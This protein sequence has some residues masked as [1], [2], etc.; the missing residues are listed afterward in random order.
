MAYQ[1]GL[2]PEDFLDM[3]PRD[4]ILMQRA[5]TRNEERKD[6]GEWTRTRWLAC[7]LMQPHLRKGR[8]LKPKDLAVF[9]W[10]TETKKKGYNRKQIMK[11]AEY[12]RKL[13]EKINKENGK[14]TD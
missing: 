3:L 12:A 1:M 5:W 11:E 6:Q 14:K 7:I 10:E 2:T 4:F 13:Y 9:P 8:K